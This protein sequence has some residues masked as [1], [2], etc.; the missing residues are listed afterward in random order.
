MPNT[1]RARIR[2][3]S[4]EEG[5]RLE[6]ARD[7]IKPQLKLGDIFTSTVVHAPAGTTIFDPGYIYDVQLEI[8]FWEQYEN[9]FDRNAPAELYEGSRKIAVGEFLMAGPE[10]AGGSEPR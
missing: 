2:F 6:P 3:L 9:L 8:T 10:Q 5:G 4:P 1:I 7:R